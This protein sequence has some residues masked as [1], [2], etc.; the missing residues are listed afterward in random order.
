MRPCH[1]NK[2]TKQK[3]TTKKPNQKQTRK[4]NF[5]SKNTNPMWDETNKKHGL[6]MI[7]KHVGK[8]GNQIIWNMLEQRK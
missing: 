5:K 6:M 7:E 4:I 3:T 2:Q 8:T 1:R